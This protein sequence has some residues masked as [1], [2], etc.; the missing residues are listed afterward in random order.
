MASSRHLGRVIALQA[1]YEYSFHDGAGKPGLLDGI[2]D[3]HLKHR[4]K[5]L[6]DKEFTVNL[7]KG[8]VERGGQLD[9]LIQPAA[10]QRPL[11]EIPLI[12]HRILQISVYELL[13]EK[14]V[15]PKVAIN[16]AVELAKYFG[17]QNSS[18]FVNGVLGTVYRQLQE[19]GKVEAA[20]SGPAEKAAVE[21]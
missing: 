3:R 16:E 7:A 14:D 21:E 17:G 1:L 10:P 2:L 8:V 5:S 4:A 15:P 19:E 13:H 12:D 20:G 6:G 9:E 18:K 11:A